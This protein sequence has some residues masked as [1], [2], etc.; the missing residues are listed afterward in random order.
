MIA[1]V[2]I[3]PAH[4]HHVLKVFVDQII[5]VLRLLL[6]GLIFVDQVN[7]YN[8]KGAISAIQ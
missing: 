7:I 1:T 5:Y 3:F 6:V 8:I 2:L 4:N